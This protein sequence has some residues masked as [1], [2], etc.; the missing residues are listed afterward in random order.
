MRC[1]HHLHIQA[2]QGGL[3]RNHP[4]IAPRA[5][6]LT[7]KRARLL[8]QRMCECAPWR[9]LRRTFPCDRLL[10]ICVPVK[11]CGGGATRY[12]G[13]NANRRNEEGIHHSFAKNSKIAHKL[14][15]VRSRTRLRRM[16]ILKR[17][18]PSLSCIQRI[19][20]QQESYSLV[21]IFP[22]RKLLFLAPRSIA[23]VPDSGKR[24][25]MMLHNPSSERYHGREEG[26]HHARAAARRPYPRPWSC[27]RAGAT[28][29]SLLPWSTT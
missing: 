13:P 5:Q 27:L 11:D 20:I 1:A 16:Q 9:R 2:P 21:S 10:P 15:P 22:F 29:A 25:A 3:L 23:S 24:K 18:M 26:G 6:K 14:E 4:R 8:P 28:R 7:L 17:Q 19:R 12:G